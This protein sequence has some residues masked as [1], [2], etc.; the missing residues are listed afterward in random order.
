M[1][2]GEDDRPQAD[3]V[4]YDSEEVARWLR[5][6][7]GMA[8]GF[9]S[10]AYA[11]QSGRFH[12]AGLVQPDCEN[13]A[14]SVDG[15]AARDPQGIYVRCTTLIAE[16]EVGRRGGAEA[17]A[18][19]PML[20]SDI[21]FGT[22]GHAHPPSASLPLPPDEKA[23]RMIVAESG[24]PTP[25]VWVHS[26]GGLY[27]IWIL[28]EP[29]A[30]ELR[31]SEAEVTSMLL[32]EVLGAAA[33]R[34]GYDDGTGVGDLSRVLR[35]PGT[36]NRKEG[37][38]RAC[39]L[40]DDEGPLYTF[41]EM[42]DAVASAANRYAEA[43]GPATW[44]STRPN[45]SAGPFDV[46]GQ[47]ASWADVLTPAGYTLVRSEAD[48]SELWLR[49]ARDGDKP[50]SQYSIRCGYG[51]VPV[52]VV[53]SE[54]T[55]LPTGAG[56]R[57]THG[58]LFAHLFHAGDE[59][60]AAS[61]LIA[62]AAGTPGTTAAAALP[63]HV[64]T[65]IQALTQPPA[66]PWDPTGDPIP[67]NTRAP[68]P[69]FPIHSLPGPV[70]AMVAAVSEFTQTDPAM[71]GTVALGVLA[72]SAGGR[73][74]IEIRPGW[75]EPVNLYTVVVAHPGERK[76][77]VLDKM[78]TPLVDAEHVLA[79]AVRADRVELQTLREIALKRA[80]K[81]RAEA[82][83]ADPSRSKELLSQA[84]TATTMAEEIDVPPVPRLVADDVT[85][86]ACISLL[87]EQGG[88]LAVISGEGGIFEIISGRYSNNVPTLDVWLKGHSGD[89][90]HVD[91]KGRDP[92]YI[93]HP[94]LT[95]VLM[96]QPTLLRKLSHRDL[97]RG[98]GLLARFLY[99]LPSSRVGKR[100]IGS[101]P[102]PQQVQDAYA[103]T[104]TALVEELA[105]W[106]DPVILELTQDAH[107]R[108]VAY[109]HEVE[110]KLGD[111]GQLSAVVD[112]GSKLAGAT[113]RV[114]ALIHLASE[115]TAA[116]R[117]P[118]DA[119]TVS[120]AI[121]IAEY[122]AQSALAAYDDMHADVLLEDAEYLLTVL[123]RL[124]SASVSQRDIMTAASRDRFR[125][126][127]DLARPL[128]ILEEH[129]F[130]CKLPRE[131][132]EG[133]GRPRSQQWELHPSLRT[134]RKTTK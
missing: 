57:L 114:A 60:A 2:R 123:E 43:R 88:R 51:G 92:E 86:E 42:Q 81:M 72:A 76:S 54:A 118:V 37:L 16:P 108:V 7:F 105:P 85:P 40:E 103:A 24:L 33:R 83:K 68:L 56:H 15:I 25:S 5:L 126:V 69:T 47:Q 22:V 89:Q 119:A 52:A 113:L 11:D 100:K 6:I 55:G 90:L 78:T 134:N 13:A 53:F 62:A 130:I 87:A 117:N 45:S 73:A 4:R 67:L 115:P 74:Q 41:E 31:R 93:K 66:N 1:A 97:F 95:L 19:L 17:S 127:G 63:E 91:R 8:Q 121:D 84:V 110:A 58:R 32:Q 35:I 34:L 20:W 101:P 133:P 61:D 109:E 98:R 30:L 29:L 9:I 125:K 28:Q 48:G 38:A 23:A 26:G 64:L 99:A 3:A 79:D 46:L 49:P 128:E 71:S 12:A 75:R 44:P 59:S 132:S 102:I 18:S 129:G 120:K 77:A 80:D 124:G 36:V 111:T 27:A 104:V 131:A 94:A 112:W 82:A 116:W 10:I 21:D 65:A 96:V 106:D 50:S 14:A 70:A 39:R 107:A 122:Y